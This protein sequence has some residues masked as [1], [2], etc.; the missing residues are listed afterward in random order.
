VVVSESFDV[1]VR[2]GSPRKKGILRARITDVIAH[3]CSSALYVV[4]CQAQRAVSRQKAPH[5]TVNGSLHRLL[6]QGGEF[7]WQ[8]QRKYSE[9]DRLVSELRNDTAVI[10]PPP[11]R[12][13]ASTTSTV[14]RRSS[15]RCPRSGTS[16]TARPLRSQ[17]LH[18]GLL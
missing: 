6:S 3:I 10:S 2:K 12:A 9:F 15:P 11:T 16:T 18:V 14:V 17:L 13:T 5:L 1:D 4:T 8:V 7:S